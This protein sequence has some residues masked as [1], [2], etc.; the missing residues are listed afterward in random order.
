MHRFRPTA[1]AFLFLGSLVL[2]GALDRAEAQTTY[3]PARGVFNGFLGQTNVVECDNANPLAVTLGLTLRDSAG[4]LIGSRPV[5]LAAFGSTHTMLNDVGNINDNYGTYLLELPTGQEL[6]GDKISC[7]TAFYRSARRGAAK[8]FEYAYVLPVE[9]PQFG[10]LAGVFNSMNPSFLDTPTQNWL[11]I[12][13]LDSSSFSANVE[14]YAASGVLAKVV[15]VSGLAPNGRV[16]VPIGH[17][18]GQVTGIYR[19]V[20]TDGSQR[21]DAFVIR[22]NSLPDGTYSFAFPLRALPGNCS[23]E[24]VNASTMGNGLTDNWFEVANVSDKTVNVTVEVRDR[25]GQLLSSEPKAIPPFSQNHTFLSSIIDPA[26]MGN[27]GSARVV[28]QDPN[29]KLVVQSAFYGHIP[30]SRTVEWSYAT[31]A[32]GQIPV[33]PGSQLS[34]PVNT[35][36]GMGNWLKLADQSQANSTL[37][38]NVY[39]AAGQV[40]ASGSQFISAGGTGDVGVHGMLPDNSVG[41]VITSPQTST[42]EFN[43]EVLRT[44][45]RSRDGQLG[46]IISIPGVVQQSGIEGNT[47]SGFFGNPQSLAEYRGK[48]T[49]EEATHLFDRAA[50]GGKPDDIF[51]ARNSGLRAAV[52]RLTTFVPTPDLDQGAFNW[53]DG[54]AAAD[55]APIQYSWNGVRYF[56]L[57]HLMNTPNIFKERMAFIW[58]DLFAASCRVINSTS[59][60][61]ECYQYVQTLRSQALGNFRTLSQDL[62]KSYLMLVWLNGNRNKKGRPDENYAREWWEL[63]SLGEKSKHDGA[64]P[65]YSDA[66]IAEAARA[67]TGFRTQIV[68]GVPE[69]SFVENN[70]D[71]GN[72]TLWVNTPYQVTGNFKYNDVVDLTLDHRP[73]AAQWIAKR[74]F[75]AFVHDHPS[76]TVIN[77]L[78]ELLRRNNFEVAPVVRTI[79]LSEAMFSADAR[80]GRVKDPL[81]YGI[82]FLRQT[83]VP[84]L[85]NNLDTYLTSMGLT[86][87]DPPDVSGWPINRYKASE[88]SDYFM[89]WAPQYV[90]YI[91]NLLRGLGSFQGYTLAGLLPSPAATG[92][93]T[94]DHIARLLDVQMTAQERSDYIYYM[95]HLRNNNGSTSVEIFNPTNASMVRR[96]VGGLLWM[97]GQH[98]SY[99]T[100]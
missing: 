32:R 17:P 61:P 60:L 88:K 44:L 91:T 26:K 27:L 9:N 59:E 29:D 34:I 40:A 80:G 99:Y 86:I 24:P 68:G 48:L 35:F 66:D 75:T 22:Y 94:V 14:L 47:G 76:H 69:V 83:G 15:T 3:F 85:V 62:T 50:F 21:Y 72:K 54:D 64:V 38:Y 79:L 93:E 42:A 78:A 49:Q 33:R 58:H 74:L 71:Q 6:L 7:R 73:E 100:F 51:L 12:I 89:A 84:V 97:L 90:N 77:Q 28:C 39:N 13:N 25:N 82:G 18:D 36:L 81:T 92:A 53:I 31:Q 65:V 52:D 10:S 19:I 87:T 11:S 98:E 43:G 5:P 56:W 45:T 1:F 41:S 20:P 55:A 30:N 8:V 23:G 67:F 63:F 2:F 57:Q 95:D 70:H 37:Q 4:N 46:N 96:K 16:D